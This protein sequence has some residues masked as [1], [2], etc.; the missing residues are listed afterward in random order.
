MS[1]DSKR[2][3]RHE[4]FVW[5][6]AD[7]IVCRMEVKGFTLHLHYRWYGAHWFLSDGRHIETEIA[8]AVAKDPRVVAV[9]DSLFDDAAG[10]TWRYAGRNFYNPKR[11]R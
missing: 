11:R 6:Q 9:G 7:K 10:Q 3:R 8:E 4:N 2:R 5:R 1:T